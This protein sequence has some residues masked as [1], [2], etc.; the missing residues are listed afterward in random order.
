MDAAV[1]LGV[2][3]PFRDVPP[4]FGYWLGTR[5]KRDFGTKPSTWQS[6]LWHTGL[7]VG[8]EENRKVL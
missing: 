6:G 8:L 3:A 2:A 5:A 4:Q 7:E 1:K